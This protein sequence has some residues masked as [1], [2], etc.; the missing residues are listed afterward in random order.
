[1]FVDW[2]LSISSTCHS[3][4]G[5]NNNNDDDDD[6]VA[7]VGT[8][9]IQRPFLA[10]FKQVVEP[11]TRRVFV[12]WLLSISSTCHST[13]G[14][15]NSNDDDDDDDDNNDD[16]N[17]DDNDDNNNDNNNNNNNNN[18]H[19][20]ELQDEHSLLCSVYTHSVESES[21]LSI[22]LFILRL[23][24]IKKL[25]KENS[26]IFQSVLTEM[27]CGVENLHH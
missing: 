23:L 17:D 12:D 8:D 10:S 3:T 9:L 15:N 13:S 2:L 22:F 4:S 26:A 24:L 14:T 5:T 16:D 7:D 6:D 27:G 1:M 25:S 19:S 21:L 11:G 18:Y 20:F